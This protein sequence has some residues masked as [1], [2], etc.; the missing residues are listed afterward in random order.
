VFGLVPAF[1]NTRAD[2][3]GSLKDGTLRGTGGRSGVQTGLLVMQ[4]ALS[5]VVLA[6][7]GLFVRSLRNIRALDL[8]FDARHIVLAAVTLP[9]SGYDSAAQAAL[10]DRAVERLSAL[11]GVVGVSYEAVSPFRGELGLP[12]VLPGQ[13]SASNNQDTFTNFVGPDFLRAN[14]TTLRS[15]RD[16]SS[17]DRSG[18]LPVTVVN[19]TMA[20]RLWP[21]ANPI[22]QCMKIG[23]GPARPAVRASCTYVV[24]VMADAKYM[25]VTEEPKAFFLLPNSQQRLTVGRGNLGPTPTL[26]VRGRGDP[27]RLA[28]EV[29]QAMETLAPDLPPVDVRAL[30]DVVDP[31]IQPYRISAVLF[32]SFGL[33]AL[34][35]AAIGLYGV[36]SYVVAQRTREVGLRLALGA[37]GSDVRALMVR[38]G[39]APALLGTAI[40]LI[41][42]LYVTRF[43]SSQLYGISPTDPLTLAA[44]AMGLCAVALVA[45]YFPARRAAGVDPVIAMRVE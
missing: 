39:M 13:D 45:C 21:N 8:G 42:A 25:E 12:V 35:L 4:A 41:G 11:P 24:G 5:L 22:G 26:V 37:R 44:V 20:H 31:Q 33:V 17:Q 18:T 32:T 27:H 38:Q 1:I 28:P 10:Y 9:G 23:G 6:G 36:V 7:A 15:G 19:E 43:F 3:A 34:F 29:R 40:G 16:I 2:L 14:G 30:A